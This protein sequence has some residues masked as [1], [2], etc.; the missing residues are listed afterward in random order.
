MVSI[1]VFA[2]C[3]RIE[4]TGPPTARQLAT[5]CIR[6]AA[7]GS[8]VSVQSCI[9]GAPEVYSNISIYRP[10]EIRCL[11]NGSSDCTAVLACLD[12]GCINGSC[13]VGTCS[14]PGIMRCAGTRIQ[15]CE[16]NNVLTEFD[17]AVFENET[18]RQDGSFPSCGTNNP[19]SCFSSRCDGG[20]FVLCS[21][22]EHRI[23]CAELY[24]G[25]LCLARAESCGFADECT[26]VQEPTCIG[27]S[28]KMCVLGKLVDVD[29]TEL[30]F[31]RCSNAACA[32]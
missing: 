20:T 2:A 4:S 30:D 28:L 21:G 17:C 23:S 22:E 16:Y 26:T 9:N 32:N 29:C 10:D 25:G 24:S 3:A 13:Q 14:M 19:V 12:D 31:A 18:C 1:A 7:C 27:N 6:Y 11:A 15:T 8:A 5:A